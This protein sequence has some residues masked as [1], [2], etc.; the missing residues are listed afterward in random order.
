MRIRLFVYRYTLTV[1]SGLAS[2]APL[3]HKYE[4]TL[5]M[6]VYPIIFLK[7]RKKRA[8]KF[9]KYMYR[10]TGLGMAFCRELRRTTNFA[11]KL[12]IYRL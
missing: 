12:R 10:P 11:N 9:I 5:Y 4:R 6:A 2:R 1:F 3:L 7:K 8:R